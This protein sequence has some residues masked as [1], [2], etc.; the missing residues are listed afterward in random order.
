M[1]WRI[2]WNCLDRRNIRYE[3]GSGKYMDIGR[4]HFGA[5]VGDNAAIG[6]AVIILP[7]RYV[8]NNSIIQAG[9]IYCKN[10]AV[11]GY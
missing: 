5:L 1:V 10:E 2:F 11:T 8:P 9:T 6:A 7:G 4:N 3:I